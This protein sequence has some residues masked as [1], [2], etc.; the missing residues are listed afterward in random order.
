VKAKNAPK[1]IPRPTSPNAPQGTGS[2]GSLGPSPKLAWGLVRQFRLGF[3]STDF[4]RELQY[5]STSAY[6]I[7]SSLL[8]VGANS[9]R[10]RP[11]SIR[12]L[13]NRTSS[14]T[15]FA[16]RARWAT[17]ASKS[18]PYGPIRD[19]FLG[20]GKDKMPLIFI[21]GGIFGSI[22]FIAI[23]LGSLRVSKNNP[24]IIY[25]I[26]AVVLCLIG[27]SVLK[28]CLFTPD[29]IVQLN[30]DLKIWSVRRRITIDSIGIGVAVTPFAVGLKRWVGLQRSRRYPSARVPSG[31]RAPGHTNPLTR[32]L[33]GP[34]K[35]G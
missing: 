32:A 28:Y 10:H 27:I 35:Y 16:L 22:F 12:V 6:L 5:L 11:H 14:K 13:A 8:A 25:S 21:F 3:G 33:Y 34:K 24:L 31:P 7:P 17:W 9:W 2:Q 15:N 29:Q 4:L 18:G 20:A 23:L 19:V 30:K 1:E 26:I